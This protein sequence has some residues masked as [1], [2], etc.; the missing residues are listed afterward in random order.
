M[1]RPQILT[2]FCITIT[3]ISA[4]QT[5]LEKFGLQSLLLSF[6][7]DILGAFI[8]GLKIPSGQ[9]AALE[10]LKRLCEMREVLS[11]EE[12]AYVVHSINEVLVGDGEHTGDTR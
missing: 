6:K 9:E 12:V 11:D 10:G 2:L 1:H 8:A 3:A 7:D 4:N 5:N